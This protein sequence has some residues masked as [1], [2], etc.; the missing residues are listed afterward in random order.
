MAE[1]GGTNP[2][3]ET[4]EQTKRQEKARKNI[5]SGI[6]SEGIINNAAE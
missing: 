1:K 3:K 5:A 6:K 2:S 4:E